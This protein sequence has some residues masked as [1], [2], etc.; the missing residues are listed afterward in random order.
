[1]GAGGEVVDDGGRNAASAGSAGE[2]VV[3]GGGA[4]VA[5]GLAN[6]RAHRR[7]IEGV[8]VA[9]GERGESAGDQL[10]TSPVRPERAIWARWGGS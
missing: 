6:R 2:S 8:E 5:D 10:R 7:L 9:V 3:G 1:M 4:D